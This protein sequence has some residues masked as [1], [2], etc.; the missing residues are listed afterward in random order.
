M[1]NLVRYSHQWLHTRYKSTT[2][3]NIKHSLY[4]DVTKQI[5]YVQSTWK[6]SINATDISL[7]NPIYYDRHSF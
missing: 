4:R 1:H 3:T 7:A 2:E 6:Q 5:I